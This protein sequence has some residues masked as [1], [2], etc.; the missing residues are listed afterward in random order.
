MH[1]RHRG[2]IGRGLAARA[3]YR[4]WKRGEIRQGGTESWRRCQ[5]A[6]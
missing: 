4:I 5:N 3:A 2:G 1:E 6:R